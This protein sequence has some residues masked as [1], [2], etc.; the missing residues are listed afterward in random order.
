M[1][2]IKHIYHLLQIIPLCGMTVP[3]EVLIVKG[4][5]FTPPG[6]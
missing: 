2:T 1:I 4:A 3:V 5:N 6:Y